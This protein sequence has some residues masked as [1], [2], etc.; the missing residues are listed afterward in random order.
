MDVKIW[1]N[2]RFVII[3]EKKLKFQNATKSLVAFWSQGDD[4]L[5]VKKLLIQER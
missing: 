4:L 2:M 1:H 3:F 5:I